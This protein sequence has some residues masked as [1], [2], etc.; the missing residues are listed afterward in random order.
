MPARRLENRIK[1]L[2]LEPSSRIEDRVVNRSALRITVAVISHNTRE[3]LRNCLCSVLADGPDQVMVVDN[4]STDGSAAMVQREFPQVTL[5][6]NLINTG[7]GAAANQAIAASGDAD[8][9]LLLNADTTVEPGTQRALQTYLDQ[10]PRSA[11]VG[12]RLLN[13]D[14]SLQPSCYPF[15]TPGHSLVDLMS[16][17]RVFQA[18]PIVGGWY[19][20]TWPHDRPRVVPWVLGAAIA[21]RRS[22]FQMVQGFDES[23]FMYNEDVDLSYRLRFAGWE[24]H[25]TPGATV[26]HV[27]HA[28]TRQYRRAMA[29]RSV[30][31]RFE[32]YRRHYTSRQLLELRIVIAAGM[33]A[34]TLRDGARRCIAA[35]PLK[36]AGLKEDLS[37]W[38]QMLK[39]VVTT[40]V[41]EG[42][43][44]P[45]D[46]PSQ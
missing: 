23:F 35:D 4:A 20:R 27:H 8:Y 32:F 26:M 46:Q 42:R 17:D 10:H 43:F 30:R 22:A 25:F 37:I 14:G 45:P 5:Q 36:Q 15:P 2:A 38:W 40:R 24:T 11:I 3:L 19:V 44:N 6:A 12:P 18:V 16:L 34:K 39:S 7:F 33:L 29:L 31:G 41:L 21:V 1:A 13:V 28:S 9:V